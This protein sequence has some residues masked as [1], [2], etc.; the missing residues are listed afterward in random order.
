MKEFKTFWKNFVNFKGRARRREYWVAYCINYAISLVILSIGF[1][2]V[3]G[4]LGGMVAEGQTG[5]LKISA[6]LIVGGIIIGI[7]MIYMIVMMIGSIAQSVRRCHDIGKPGWLFLICIL[8]SFLCGIGSIAWFVIC[9][10]P[11]QEGDNEWGSD[12]K[13]PGNDEFADSNG[14]IIA[15]VSVIVAIIFYFIVVCVGSVFGVINDLGGFEALQN[16]GIDAVTAE[17]GTED[18]SLYG[19]DYS[20]EYEI[21][22]ETEFSTEDVTQEETTAAPVDDKGVGAGSGMFSGTEWQSFQIEVDGTVI[23][24]PCTYADI[25]NLGYSLSDDENGDEQIEPN[26]Y[27]SSV[28]VQMGGREFSVCFY[29]DTAE[30]KKLTECKIY[31]LRFD[32]FYEVPNVSLPNGIS[33]SSTPEDIREAMGKEQDGYVSD[34]SDYMSMDYYI[35]ESYDQKGISFTFSDGKMSELKIENMEID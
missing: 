8:G 27:T 29:N 11:S 23:T 4:S 1:G 13:A 35:G 2:F 18:I 28:Y 15:V 25:Q 6:G 14:I 26:N 20:T 9:C 16:G 19:G 7:A 24:L 17:P 34:D 22:S 10:L 5:E 30:T 21:S 31:A 33:M 12:P 3:F 32:S